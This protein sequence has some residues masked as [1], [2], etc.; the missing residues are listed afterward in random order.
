MG[1]LHAVLDVFTA[2]SLNLTLLSPNIANFSE[3]CLNSIKHS[4]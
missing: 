2:Q 3:R 4:G 1:I